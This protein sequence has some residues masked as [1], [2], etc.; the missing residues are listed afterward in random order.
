IFLTLM[1]FLVLSNPRFSRLDHELFANTTLTIKGTKPCDSIADIV[2]SLKKEGLTVTKSKLE[3][4]GD[5]I[6]LEL[7]VRGTSVF[8]PEE[9]LKLMQKIPQ[10]T[11]ISY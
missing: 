2:E 4:E 8:T 1:V 3:D 10:I 7:S 11:S 6:V 5:S 9:Q